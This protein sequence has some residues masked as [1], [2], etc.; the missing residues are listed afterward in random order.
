MNGGT[1]VCAALQRAGQLLK[2]DAPSEA[3]RL[4]VLLT[5]GRIDSL[6]V[7]VLGALRRNFMCLGFWRARQL[8]VTG[9]HVD[10]A[11]AGGGRHEERSAQQQHL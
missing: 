8:L 3:L 10:G 9:L 11:S 1:N 5:D 2:R 7:W 6:Q 4:V